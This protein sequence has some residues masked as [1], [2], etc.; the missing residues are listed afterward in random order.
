MDSD[1]PEE[2][3][4]LA[5][6]ADDP[7]EKIEYFSL[8]LDH[9]DL[10]PDLWSNE[11]LALV[12]N[13][14]GIALFFLGRDKEALECFKMSVRLNKN[15]VDVWCNMGIIHF[16]IGNHEAAIKCYNR[17]LRLDPSNEN[18]W[19]NKGD[20][21]GVMGMHNEAIECYSKVH[22]EIELDNKFA[23]VWN[24]KGL[25]YFGLGKYEDAVDCFNRVLKIDPEHID[26]IENL[27]AAMSKVKQIN[28]EISYSDPSCL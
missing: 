27:K 9:N 18:A 13:N 10:D 25:A 6:D 24:K 8:I 4:K 1:T 11:A 26:A 5:F 20:I 21:L 3:F 22:K 7:E 19:V 15:D 12:W 28:E 17:I 16:N 14:K 23:V 2:W